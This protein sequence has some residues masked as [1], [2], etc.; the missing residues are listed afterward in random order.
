MTEQMG[1]SYCLP[2]SAHKGTCFGCER[3]CAQNFKY[4]KISALPQFITLS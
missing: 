2:E 1:I 4:G 3:A